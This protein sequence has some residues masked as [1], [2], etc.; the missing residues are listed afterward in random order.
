MMRA[1][2]FPFGLLI[3]LLLLLMPIGPGGMALAASD[4]DRFLQTIQERAVEEQRRNAEREQAFRAD[5]DGARRQVREMRQRLEAAQDRQERLLA[6]FET[7]ELALMALEATLRERQGDL[8]EM[9]GVVRQSAGDV[10]AQFLGSLAMADQPE[11]LDFVHRLSNSRGLPDI[12]E[13]ERFWMLMLEEMVATGRAAPFTG[14][15]VAPDGLRREAVIMRVGAFNV[16]ADGR[17]L[18]HVEGRNQF[19]ELPRQPRNRYLRQARALAEAPPGEVRPFA[20]DPS[21]GA[22]L[23]QLVQSPSLVE[24]VMQG[25]EIG[26]VILLLGLLGIGLFAVRFTLLTLVGR[27]VQR[28]LRTDRAMADNP[29]GRILGLYDRNHQVDPETLEI[30]MDEAIL[31]EVPRLERG[32]TF[33]KILAA[34]APLLGLLGT[35]VGMINTFQSITLFGTGDPQLMAGGISQA[36][37]TTALGLTVAIP[38]LLLHSIAAAKS[39]GLV[40]IMEEQG[41][42]LLAEHMQRQ[43]A[44]GCDG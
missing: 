25:R 30:R 19:L 42:G 9:F 23:A 17:Y 44:G 16:I 11:A 32:L 34:V 26:L 38:L 8:G 41:A 5:L 1:I 27:R 35:V 7:N 12:E 22:I 6:D 20:L 3:L 18:T 24:R 29:L 33:I 40:N 43:R 37:V 36:L 10:Y 13:L 39:R 31:R 4:L 2:R 28:Q 14:E 15:V 21:R